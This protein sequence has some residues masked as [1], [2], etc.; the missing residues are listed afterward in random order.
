[1]VDE[2][3]LWIDTLPKKIETVRSSAGISEKEEPLIS[4]DQKWALSA[5]RERQR[6]LDYKQRVMEHQ[7]VLAKAALEETERFEREI[8]A[9]LTSKANTLKTWSQEAHS[10]IDGLDKQDSPNSSAGPSSSA[11]ST[12]KPSSNVFVPDKEESSNRKNNGK[13]RSHWGS[14]SIRG[15]P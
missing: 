15:P 11:E 8:E 12:E 13:N 3:G 2:T 4:D 5:A 10:I 7:K 6:T 9:M 1:M 14:P